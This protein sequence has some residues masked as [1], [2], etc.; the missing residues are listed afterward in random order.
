M[1]IHIGQKI[2]EVVEAK[3][4]TQKEFGALIGKSEKMVPGI[5][6]GA[7]IKMDLLVT[8]CVALKT[9]FLKLFYEAL[10]ELQAYDERFQLEQEIK[11]LEKKIEQKEKELEQL[12]NLHKQ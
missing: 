9:D 12:N 2:K 8:I 6:R 7:H 1:T 10:P 11:A 3:G 5:Y 4:L